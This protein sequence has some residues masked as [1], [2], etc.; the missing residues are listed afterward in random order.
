ML[1]TTYALSYS[2]VVAPGGLPA[3]PLWANR[4][5][6]ACRF[7]GGA[8]MSES[9]PAV[10]VVSRIPVAGGTLIKFTHDSKSTGTPMAASVFVPAGVDYDSEIPALYWLSG[11][12]CTD[13][14]FCIKAGAFAHAARERIALVVPDTSPR[15][16][17]VPDDDSYDLGKGAGFYVD[18]TQAPWSSNFQMFSYVTEELPA[19]VE[20]NF[21]ISPTLRSIAGH[22]MGGHGALTVAF[23]SPDAWASVSAFAPICNP[24]DSAW[25][26][27][28]FT[29]YLGSVDAG[30]AHDASKLLKANGPFAQ[31][32]EILIDQGADDEF[33]ESGQLKPEVLQEAATSVGQ[34]LLIRTRSGD[35]SYC[36]WLP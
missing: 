31:L 18:A 15:G 17:G 8:K 22:S 11:L 27:K 36:A 28:A 7:H 5:H 12:T 19:I 6:A 20:A 4:P 34:P 14:N 2:L 26:Q 13:E 9:S 3:P 30:A 16:D 35:H 1:L 23:K 32:G 33:L 24:T 21:K 29:A 10:N 25:G